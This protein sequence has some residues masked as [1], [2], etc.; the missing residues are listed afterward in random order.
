M[1]PTLFRQIFP[2]KIMMVNGV[3]V[4]SFAENRSLFEAGCA[5]ADTTF[6]HS[7]QHL[8]SNFLAR[9]DNAL[10]LQQA[11]DAVELA[12]EAESKNGND[13]RNY[14][15]FFFV[16]T[17]VESESVQA[18]CIPIQ[19]SER[20]IYWQNPIHQYR[21]PGFKLRFLILNPPR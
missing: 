12:W 7:E 9:R 16:R 20:G 5:I 17:G 1:S 14:V 19:H 2:Q 8:L 4:F 21:W 3:A 10:T 15:Y 13:D 11:Q 18:V 6:T